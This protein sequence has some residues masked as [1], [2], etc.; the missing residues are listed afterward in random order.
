MDIN[1]NARFMVFGD[2]HSSFFSGEDLIVYGL[3]ES[4]LF[5]MNFHI[6]HVGPALAASLVERQSTLM[7]RENIFEVLKR[8]KP[9]EWHGV[10]FAFGEIDC[11]FHIVKRLGHQNA[12][13]TD[14][15]KHSIAVTALRYLS[16]MH[17]VKL[18][19]YHPII[20]G[21]VATNFFSI[22]YPDYPNYGSIIER[23]QITLEFTK[24]L[25]KY[26]AD[27]EIDFLSIFPALITDSLE[28]KQ[29]YYFDTIHLSQK[30]WQLTVP[31]LWSWLITNK[32]FSIANYPNTLSG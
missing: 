27:N 15:V 16:F 12:L 24:L 4:N 25:S 32:H 22:N 11:R 29:E 30:A 6:Y 5:N 9:S 28:T 20:W 13:L 18:L 21:P 31:L 10:L 7:A 26:S 23:N 19:G 8:E 14:D 3:K 2:S 17:E 1:D